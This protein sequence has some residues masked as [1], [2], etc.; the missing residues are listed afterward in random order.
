MRTLTLTRCYA[1]RPAP[2]GSILVFA[3]IILAVLAM[4]GATLILILNQ[5]TKL[6]ANVVGRVENEFAAKSGIDHATRSLRDSVT[7][8]MIYTDIGVF[9]YD[10]TNLTHPWLRKNI[11]ESTPLEPDY[12]LK[13]DPERSSAPFVSPLRQFQIDYTIPPAPAVPAS[14]TLETL[15]FSSLSGNSFTS[16]KLYLSSDAFS[17]ADT[18]TLAFPNYLIGTTQDF[19]K[20]SDNAQRNAL[21]AKTLERSAPNRGI[22]WVWISDMD[23]KLYIHGHDGPEKAGWNLDVFR[24]GLLSTPPV[25]DAES[26]IFR[27]LL[28]F[29][30]TADGNE[31]LVPGMASEIHN[32]DVKPL[33]GDSKRYRH[34]TSIDEA[35]T[36][37]TQ[38]H[39]APTNTDPEAIS[40]E[41]RDPSRI[42]FGYPDIRAQLELYFTAYRDV[43]SLENPLS[44]KFIK[45][46]S[47]AI[48]IN[49]ASLEVIAA[50]LTQIPGQNQPDPLAGNPDDH[51]PM[52]TDRCVALARRIISKRPF[53][54][55]MDFEDF[56]AAHI[57]G[58]VLVTNGIFDS[59]IEYPPTS[60]ANILT[61]PL[62]ADFAYTPFSGN[63]PIVRMIYYSMN[64]RLGRGYTP[65][66][67]PPPL[68][69][70]PDKN[71]ARNADLSNYGVQA[72]LS[73]S[74]YLEIPGIPDP[75]TTTTLDHFKLVVSPT[76]WY[77]PN[78]PY[79]QKR[80]FEFFV[81]DTQ[82]SDLGVTRDMSKITPFE[83][84]NIINSVTSVFLNDDIQTTPLGTP[85]TGTVIAA[86]DDK[87]LQTSPQGDDVVGKG[88]F[89]GPNGLLDTI[90]QGDDIVTSGTILPGSNGTLDSVI[91]GDDQKLVTEILA[92]PNGIADTW[93]SSFRPSYYSF[94]DDSIYLENFWSN[95]SESIE[96]SIVRQFNLTPIQA[97]AD[98]KHILADSIKDIITS[99]TET[100]KD[101]DLRASQNV[102]FYYRLPLK[103]HMPSP[104]IAAPDLDD[105]NLE[106]LVTW[107]CSPSGTNTR[108]SGF[109]QMSFDNWQYSYS[110]SFGPV[111]PMGDFNQYTDG[112]TDSLDDDLVYS[113]A[114]PWSGQIPSNPLLQ[115]SL[116]FD[117][118]HVN[119][120]DPT[121][122]AIAVGNGD[123]SWGPKFAFRSRFFGIYVLGRG[124]LAGPWPDPNDT[125]PK[126]TT[127]RTTVI[128]RLKSQGEKRIEAVYDALLD[129]IIWQ[130]SPITDKRALGEPAP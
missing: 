104:P 117:F 48:N 81:S 63:F 75:N 69:T 89:P 29:L 41:M 6:S 93:T 15:P 40:A 46:H 47:S 33:E 77:W 50:A 97:I 30:E 13:Y 25:P 10:A 16:S 109:Y 21:K 7:T 90:R 64:R 130:R 57:W 70:E 22:Y 88:I 110:L 98:A 125:S 85:T 79:Y 26:E 32:M 128:D 111:Q 52:T 37:L 103:T 62:E 9:G 113:S 56:L 105:A 35:A 5:S 44:Q 18:E 31:A 19:Y 34:F 20:Q 78:E 66:G 74:Q 124:E 86:G 68:S 96:Q 121:E 4:L 17:I 2:A 73:L 102:K 112:V 8:H 12:S 72:E 123:V 91:A 80:R 58:E 118:D 119:G 83:F 49:T 87:Q 61:Q 126:A 23:S 92:G 71:P 53:L 94:I 36:H 42:P 100:I 101:A 129:Q 67:A 106:H 108:R 38:L 54:C 76:E 127:Q 3:V 115:A 28:L 27:N 14:Y 99:G 43:S 60:P 65:L 55:R 116:A 1:A 39:P 114:R 120:I 59:T 11:P 45:D 51:S 82:G 24:T 122:A 107:R 95:A 84:N